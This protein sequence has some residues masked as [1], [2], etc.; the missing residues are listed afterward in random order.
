MLACLLDTSLILD[1]F[2]N[3]QPHAINVAMLFSYAEKKQVRIIV[4]GVSVI[5]MYDELIESVSAKKAKSLLN[6]LS[7]FVEIID[8]RKEYIENSFWSDIPDFEKAIQHQTV[9]DEKNYVGDAIISFIITKNKRAFH[10]TILPALNPLEAIRI[11][12]S[13]NK[14]PS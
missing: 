2:A 5:K 13:W 9:M 8:V 7:T 1:F 12:N 4:S 6:D 11:I 3:R 14:N 10:K